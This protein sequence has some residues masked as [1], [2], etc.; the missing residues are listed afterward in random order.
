M[1]TG[2]YIFVPYMITP[3]NK[4][5]CCDSSFVK[6]LTELMPPGFESLLG[7]ICLPLVDRFIQLLKVA[8]ASSR[9]VVFLYT[10]VKCK[11]S[12]W[13]DKFQ[14]LFAPCLLSDKLIINSLGWSNLFIDTALSICALHAHCGRAVGPEKQVRGTCP[15]LLMPSCSSPASISGNP[16]WMT[17]GRP[18]RFTRAKS[19]QQSWQGFD[20]E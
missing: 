8:Q 7:P 1:C 9:W 17:S 15:Q 18:G 10:H 16:F 19:L 13:Q 11:Y 6:G 20:S 12:G 2:N 5:Y 3:H 4:V 14:T